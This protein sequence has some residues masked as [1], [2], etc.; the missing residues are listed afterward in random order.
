[1]TSDSKEKSTIPVETSIEYVE[2]ISRR[3]VGSAS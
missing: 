3:E 2:A 1:M